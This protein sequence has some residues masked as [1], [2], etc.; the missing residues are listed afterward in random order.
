M[1]DSEPGLNFIIVGA[2]IAGLASAIA[3]KAAGHN[4]LVVEKE[5]QLGGPSSGFNGCARIPPNGCKILLDWGLDLS[6]AA[7]WPGFALYRYESEELPGPDLLGLV[8]WNEELLNDAGAGYL[9]FRHKDLLRVLYEAAIDSGRGTKAKETKPQVTVLFGAEVVDIDGDACSITL[10]SGKVHTGDAIIG[11]DGARGVVRRLL[12]AEEDV[13]PESDAPTGLVMYSVVIPKPLICKHGLNDM[14]VDDVACSVWMGP[15]RGSMIWQ[16]GEGDLA[17]SI[18]TP[19]SSQDGTWTE[20]AEKK[21]TDVVGRCDVRMQKLAAL[22]ENVTCVQIK[23]PHKLESW[24]SESGR[25]IALGEAAHPSPPAGLHPYSIALEDGAFI[26]KIF[27]HTRSPERIPEFFHA[28][29]EHREPR[30]SR[31]RDMD[32]EYVDVI[33]LP[34]GEMQAGR[35]AGMRANHAAGRNAMDGDLDQML[36]DFRMVFGYDAN[37]DADE[38]WINWGRFKDAP[39][40]ANGLNGQGFFQTASFSTHVDLEEQ[41]GYYDKEGED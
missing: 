5:A 15:H 16:V 38:W 14:F 39:A 30:C 12:M 3:L 31:I 6:K 20:Q 11:A 13:E 7:M 28:F 32:Q 35:D 8:R 21:F 2:S 4:V 10:K 37:D 24:V 9:L 34:D 40:S 27:S 29:Q 33:T 1:A 26:G 22:A 23:Q 18:Y 19:D 17:V 41:E 25:I 36:D